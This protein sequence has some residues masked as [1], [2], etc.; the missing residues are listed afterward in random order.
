VKPVT[1]VLKHRHVL[2]PTS[3]NI[4]NILVLDPKMKPHRTMREQKWI[5]KSHK[6]RIQR[7]HTLKISCIFLNNNIKSACLYIEVTN[8]ESSKLRCSWKGITI[9]M[10]CSLMT[11]K[12]NNNLWSI[13]RE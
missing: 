4:I 10:I 13:R 12:P 5:L 8:N 3:R 9:P 6:R 7:R 11:K 2:A 1:V